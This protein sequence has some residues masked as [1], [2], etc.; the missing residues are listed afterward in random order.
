[1]WL[2]NCMRAVC[3]HEL[4]HNRLCAPVCLQVM[5]DKT[6]H[7]VWNLRPDSLALLLSLAN[8]GAGARC[9]VL[10]N[11]GVSGVCGGHRMLR[12]Q[13]FEGAGRI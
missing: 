4:C 11:C 3:R 9:L 2:Y 5:F 7:A 12:V 8:V 1:M 6:P 13:G 10:E